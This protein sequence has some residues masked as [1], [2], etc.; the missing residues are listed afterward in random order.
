MTA[1]I[2]YREHAREMRQDIYDLSLC[3]DVENTSAQDAQA[4][5]DDLYDLA[6]RHNV[7][8]NVLANSRH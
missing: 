1:P 2:D 6:E 8:C 5:A 4:L 3:V 7:C